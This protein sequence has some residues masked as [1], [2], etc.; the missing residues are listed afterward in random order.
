MVHQLNLILLKS[1]I[2]GKIL[3]ILLGEII[4]TMEE[5]KMK[6]ITI[7]LISFI[8]IVISSCSYIQ[9]SCFQNKYQKEYKNEINFINN[10][11][12]NPI[13]SDS[14]IIHSIYCDIE[15]FKKM[16]NTKYW[17]NLEVL[18]SNLFNNNH[19]EFLGVYKIE[20]YKAS[21]NEQFG[22]SVSIEFR[23]NMKPSYQDISFIFSKI[24]NQMKLVDIRW[25]IM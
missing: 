1:I 18:Q 14:I 23:R 25:V 13:N 17:I 2:F 24:Q 10:I 7:F 22:E 3:F 20:K 19:V 8:V 9:F 15:I 12:E 16:K 6:F 11:I 5:I 21:Y 4:L